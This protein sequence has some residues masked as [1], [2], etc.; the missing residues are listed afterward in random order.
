MVFRDEL[1]SIEIL[2]VEDDPGDVELT[3]EVMEKSKIRIN[4]NVVEDG[5][6]AIEYLR[7]EGEYKDKTKPDLI[8]L[9]LNMPRKDGRETL[10]DIKNDPELKR[11]PVVILTTSNAHEDIVKTYTEG[12]SC[13][14]TK[15]VGLE[16][17]SR[18]VQ[19]IDNFWFT[20]VKYPPKK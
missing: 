6:K 19:A 5:V 12:C 7:K 17:F 14:V 20:V 13:Y 3:L 9:D 8:L 2:L 1:K 16:E 4:M 15:P 10:H 11:I 18:V